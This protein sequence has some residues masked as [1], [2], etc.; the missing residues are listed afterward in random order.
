MQK[1]FIIAYF[2]MC[3]CVFT[4][5]LDKNVMRKCVVLLMVCGYFKIHFISIYS[6]H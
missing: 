4:K 3:M 5:L 1:L 6:N 2:W